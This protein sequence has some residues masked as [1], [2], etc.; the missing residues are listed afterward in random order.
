MIPGSRGASYFQSLS[1]DGKIK[2]LEIPD[3]KVKAML[4]LLPTSMSL[5]RFK[6]TPIAP[7]GPCSS[8]LPPIP[9]T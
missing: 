2:F 8:T 9:C 3:D 5:G 6:T 1:R 4:A 7:S